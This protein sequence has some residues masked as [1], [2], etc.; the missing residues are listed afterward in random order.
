MIDFKVI[1]AV[2]SIQVGNNVFVSLLRLALEH[3]GSELCFLSI[4]P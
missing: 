1:E 2:Y 4:A 3:A